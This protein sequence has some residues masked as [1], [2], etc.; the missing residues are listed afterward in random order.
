MSQFHWDITNKKVLVLGGNG[1]VG[2][3]LT[4]R[5][6]AEHCEVFSATRRDADLLD[7]TAVMSLLASVKPDAVILAAAK[8]GGILANRDNPVEFLET[9]LLIQLNS[10]RAANAVDVGRFVFLGSS[11]IYPKYAEQPISEAS[12]MTGPLE[13]TNEAYAIAKIVG[14]RLIDSYRAEYG[15]QWI[16]VMPTNLYGPNDNFDLETSHVLPALLRRFHEAKMADAASVMIW[17]TGH[18]RREFM[19]VDD[20]ADAIL[21]L[22]R[23]YNDAGPVNIGAGKDITINELAQKVK[24]ITGFE[25]EIVHDFTK[26][27]GTPAKLIDNTRLSQAGWHPKINLDDGLN[28]TYRWY[29]KSVE[30]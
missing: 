21:F 14:I 8:V 18:A 2:A 30:A 7:P 19:H 24:A 10:I 11:C 6:K 15:R 16:S 4:R 22:L 27:D 3:A 26:P 13:P 9:N 25:G 17:G 5:L 23:H 28:S 12:L 29:V 1:L 20:C